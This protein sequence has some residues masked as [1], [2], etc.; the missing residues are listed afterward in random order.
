MSKIE[1]ERLLGEQ[2]VKITLNAPEGNILDGDMMK[3]LLHVLE[4]LKSR[5]SVKL[6][7]FQGAGDHFSFGASVEEHQGEMV[8]NMLRLFHRVFYELID[9]SIPSAALVSGQCLGGGMEL[10]ASC[11]FVYADETAEFGQ[12]E[13]K[14]GV[15][16]P[17]ASLILPLKI[18]SARADSLL[19]TGQSISA[20][21]AKVTGLVNEVF[22]ARDT[23]EEWVTAWIQREIVPK[24]ASSLKLGVMAARRVFNETV[25]LELPK[26]EKMYVEKLMATHDANEGISAFLQKRP[27]EWED[28]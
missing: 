15:Y 27:P 24:S 19:L 28:S 20:R 10:A 8:V 12:P 17:L 23:M 16:P 4:D 13:I 9:L 22:E 2:V 25:R 14:L 7:M 21:E 11:H 3:E 6:V 18:G 5:R 26:L 1:M